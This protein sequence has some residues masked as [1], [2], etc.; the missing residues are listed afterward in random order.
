MQ[1]IKAT[2]PKCCERRDLDARRWC[3]PRAAVFA[4]A[5]ETRGREIDGFTEHAVVRHPTRAC[6]RDGRILSSRADVERS[7]RCALQLAERDVASMPIWELMRAERLG[8]SAITTVKKSDI[9]ACNADDDL[10]GDTLLSCCVPPQ[11]ISSPVYRR[12]LFSINVH[13]AH[14]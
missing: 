10:Y 11:A 1:A 7:V 4:S 9:G 12:G 2:Q 5:A 14:F 6:Q 3:I 8:A 13:H